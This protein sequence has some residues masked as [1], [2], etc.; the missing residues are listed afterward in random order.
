MGRELFGTDGVRGVAG[1]YPLD[2]ATIGQVGLAIAQQFGKSGA[3][4]LIG[5]DP[6]QS[7]PHIAQILAKAINEGGVD[8]EVVSVIT[9]PGLAYL[10]RETNASA[11]VMGTASHNPYTDNGIKVFTSKGEKLTDEQE[12]SLNLAI[13]QAQPATQVGQSQTAEKLL[14]Q[15]EDFLVASAG[16]ENLANLSMAVDSANGSASGLAARVFKHLAI[17][18]ISLFDKPDGININ[19]GCGATNIAALQTEVLKRKLDGGV[20]LDGDGDRVVLVDAQGR[21]FNGDHM[22]YI[23]AVT[24]EQIGVVSTIMS[25]YGLETA[26]ADQGIKLER[27][28][29]GDRYVMEGLRR[30]GYKLGGEQPGHII[31]PELLATGDG[32]LAAVQ[33]MMA[34]NASGKSLSQWRDQV[35]LLPQAIVNLKVADKQVIANPKI[36]KIIEDEAADLA[37]RGRLLVRPSGTEPV[38]RIMAEGQNAKITAQAI[39]AKIEQAIKSL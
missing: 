24:G 31:L 27:T 15:Y 1:Q 5:R 37:G 34:V 8:V 7:S 39:A 14:K 12:A 32:L 4:I 26:L 18:V 3:P 13:G 21:E 10:T 38:L 2:D 30:T 25:N 9:T 36:K 19:D 17:Y 16:G 29:V 22:L 28:A 20:A 6:R 23:L 35:E 11:G 33:T